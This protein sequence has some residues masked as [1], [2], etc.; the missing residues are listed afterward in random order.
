MD[1]QA[2]LIVSILL[3]SILLWYCFV[4]LWK[5]KKEIKQLQQELDI[6]KEKLT[7]AQQQHTGAHLSDERKNMVSMVAHDLKSPLN[8]TYALIRL[9]SM[10]ADNLNEEQLDYLGKMHQIIAD[11]LSLVRNMLDIRAIESRGFEIRKENINLSNFLASSL[12][13][14][15]VL[16]DLKQ[17][18]LLFDAEPEVYFE[19]DKQYLGRI[20]DNLISNAV[21]FSDYGK[22][23][24]MTM[25]PHN[26]S[27]HIS[28]QDEGPGFKA[29]ELD[30]V[31]LKD[32]KFSAKPTGGESS[33]GLGLS[34]VKMIADKM[35]YTVQCKSEEGK[36]AEF[37]LEMPK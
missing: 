28:I 11:G 4:L 20:I 25:R 21:K 34:I 5:G 2:I 30:R 27:V 31:F 23:I 15:K 8:R 19:T 17:I 32:Q 18:E 6:Y 14:F 26:N 9:I 29:E 24:I 1:N 35:G 37:I 13:Q 7:I 36:G 3:L 16:A 10:N 12:K 33:T 22:K